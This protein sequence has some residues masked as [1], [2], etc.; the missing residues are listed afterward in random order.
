M[1][2]LSRLQLAPP[3]ALPVTGV[4]RDPAVAQCRHEVAGVGAAV[5][6]ACRSPRGVARQHCQRR[7]PLGLTVRLTQLDIDHQTVPV[8]A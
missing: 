3:L 2:S 7:L 4:R 5:C 6:A 1:P 8:L